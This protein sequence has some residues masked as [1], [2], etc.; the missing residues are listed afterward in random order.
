MLGD[1]KVMSEQL[2]LVREEA[3]YDEVYT[4]GHGLEE[5]FSWSSKREPSTHSLDDKREVMMKRK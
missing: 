1:G 4:L 5:G 3:D 2:S